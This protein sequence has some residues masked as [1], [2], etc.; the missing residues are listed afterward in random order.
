MELNP[1]HPVTS[2]LHDHWHKVVAAIM[3]KLGKAELQ[4]T[5]EDLSKLEKNVNIVVKEKDN[6][7]FV[8]IVDDKTAAMLARKEGGRTIDN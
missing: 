4:L 3:I 1:N 6:S 2:G 8:S 5:M 7:L